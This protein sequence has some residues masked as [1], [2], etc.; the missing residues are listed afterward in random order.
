MSLNL[1]PVFPDYLYL[2]DDR[3]HNN[4]FLGNCTGNNTC[5][6]NMSYWA[7]IS[8]DL[9][10]VKCANQVRCGTEISLFA[11]LFICTKDYL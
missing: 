11:D 9:C 1:L 7:V 10:K 5:G 4:Y 2:R 8:S 3:K 6:G